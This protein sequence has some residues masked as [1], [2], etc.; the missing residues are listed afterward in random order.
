MI[1]QKVLEI[2]ALVSYSLRN[3]KWV[4]NRLEIPIAPEDKASRDAYLNSKLLERAVKEKFG[5]DTHVGCNYEKGDK[6][7]V[8]VA[9]TMSRS[10]C[11]SFTIS[12]DGSYHFDEE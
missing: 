6:Q 5:S 1:H 12:E 3:G 7:Y 8:E 9:V 2:P 4:I 10:Y 11:Y